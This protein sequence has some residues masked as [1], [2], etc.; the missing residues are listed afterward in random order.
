MTMLI[1]DRLQIISKVKGFQG[2]DSYFTKN[3]MLLN[4]K[5]TKITSFMYFILYVTRVKR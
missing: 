3:V 2:F 5:Q 4:I 1:T